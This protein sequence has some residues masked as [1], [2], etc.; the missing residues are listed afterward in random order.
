VSGAVVYGRQPVREALRGRRAVHEIVVTEKARA[1]LTWLDDADCLVTV[2]GP[3]AVGGL[4]ASSDHQGIAARVDDYPYVDA[5][6]LLDHDA[7]LIVVLDGVTD[8]HNLG[9]IARSAECA[10]ADGL[11]V[12]RHGA[13]PV[14]AAVVKASAG[15]VEHLPI[16]VAPNLADWLQR[17]KRPGVWTYAAAT[18]GATPYAEADYRDGCIFVLGAEGAGV[19]PRVLQACD[20]VVALP[21]AGRIGSLNVSVAA[22]VLLYEAVRQRH[23]R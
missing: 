2:T 9:A 15:A 14:T 8:P 7:P 16:A 11:V 10:G 1:A 6:D 17:A 18:E 4:A 13:A 23:V 12:P 21:M 20:A 19:R 3:D 5:F 22:G